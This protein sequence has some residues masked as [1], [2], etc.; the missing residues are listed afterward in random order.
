[1]NMER[2]RSMARTNIEHDLIMATQHHDHKHRQQYHFT[3]YRLQPVHPFSTHSI[4]PH[5]HLSL[6]I[7]R[8]SPKA[9]RAHRHTQHP[10]APLS[11]L[12]T[13]PSEES[14]LDRL[15]GKGRRA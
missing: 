2:A 5:A 15:N 11:A 9:L 6:S 7:F 3:T 8:T 13:P 10:N 12:R 4:T 14:A 1:M